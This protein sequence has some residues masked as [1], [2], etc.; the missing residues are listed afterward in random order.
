VLSRHALQGDNKVFQGALL[1]VTLGRLAVHEVVEASAALHEVV[2]TT[3]DAEDTEG[4]DPD[5]DNTHNVSALA[6]KPTEDSEESGQD[7]DNQDGAGELPRGKRRPEGAIGTGDEDQ[8][9]LSERDLEEDNFIDGTLVLSDTTVLTTD[10]H[11]SEGNPGTGSQDNTEKD[12]HTPKLGQVPLDGSLRV[13]SVVVGNG[14]SG[15]ISEDGN[16]DDKVDVQAGVQDS[17]PQAEEDLHVQGKSDTVDN[18]GVHAVENL[19][20]SL[21]GIDD[22]TKTRSKEDDIGSRASGVRGTLD[23]N[24]SVSLL[25]RRSIVDTVTSHGDEVTTLL[26]N[27]NDGVLVLGEDLG[28]TIS[29]LDEIVDLGTWHVTA[30]TE[31]KTLSVVDIGA[32][33]ELARSLTGNANGVTSKHL[34]GQTENLGL[35]DGAGSIVTGR[36][37]AGHDT[38]NLPSTLT[39]L[40]GNTEG[41]ET[42]GSEVGDAV[43]VGLVNV[44]GDGVVLLDSLEHEKRGTLD[45][46]DAL[47]LG[48]LDDGLDLLGDGVKGVELDNL[49]LGQ[50]TLGAGIVLQGLEESLVD[51][52]DTL[53]LA[54]SSQASSKHQ[55]IRLDTL[56]SVRLRQGE[57]VLGQGTSLVRAENLNTSERLDGRQLL[58]DGLLLGKI[59][60]TDSH[61]GGDDSG[62]TDG[63]TDDCDTEGEAEDI[64]DSIG[65]V[66]RR[67]PDNEKSKDDEDEQNGANAVE[68]LSEVTS[69]TS[70][71]G[72]EGSSATD[73][74]VVTSG[75]DD[76]K[77]LTTLDGRGGVAVVTL[78]LVDSERLASDG[79]LINLEEGVLGN[80]A[81]VGGNDG[82][83]LNLQDITRNDLRGL[84]LLEGAVTEDNSLESQSLLQFVDNGTG[85]VLLEETNAG[86]EQ[87]KTANDTEIDPILE[88]GSK[89]GSS[90]QKKRVS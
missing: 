17:D 66:E 56:N 52:I 78:M 46:D 1:L 47:A 38:E 27:L 45:A 86:V 54:G 88:T 9:V 74:G 43:L 35:V 77:G 75:S 79:R 72:H 67:H 71:L 48:G 4:E 73:E 83:L 39:T 76:N 44:I 24:T 69:A 10:E 89:D 29:S 53:L 11:G 57:L 18:V 61:G 59:G 3:H 6:D 13:R 40:A 42:T 23:G 30:A 51:G 20:G 68:D 64:D 62:Q 81:A 87:Q 65:T 7:I 82:T 2:K 15:D 37:R 14:K 63:D 70:G 8:P 12:G 5:T 33:T 28:E 21:Q 85:L 49:V 31:T 90:L 41:A 34:D 50:D 58:D 19:A 26:E 36:V 84:N 25:Q 60:S 32:E 80:D 16:E 55:V 22:G